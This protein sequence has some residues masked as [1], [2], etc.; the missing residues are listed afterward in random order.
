[1]IYLRSDSGPGNMIMDAVVTLATQGRKTFDRNG[2][3]ARRGQVSDQLLKDSLKHQYY[4]QAPPKTT[5]REM[6][7]LA[8]S[9]PFYDKGIRMGLKPDDI[10]ATA[11]ALTAHTICD[12]YRKFL[13]EVPDQVILCGGGARNPALVQMLR[14]RLP[15]TAWMTTGDFGID[16]DA[17]EAVSFAMLAWATMNGIANNA[18]TA[19]GARHGA[20]L[21]KIIP[22]ASSV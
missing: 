6:F 1:M 10:I 9:Q 7:G 16:S 11:T 5:G 17:K 22:G 8:Y 14:E 21:G 4:R 15:E 3:M 18:P 12:A 19:T 13:P 2:A 20:I